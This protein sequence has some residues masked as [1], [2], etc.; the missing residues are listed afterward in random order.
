MTPRPRALIPLLL[1]AALLGAIAAAGALVG[2]PGRAERIPSSFPPRAPSPQTFTSA[3]DLKE[4]ARIAYADLSRQDWA[5]LG[6][7][8]APG[9]GEVGDPCEPGTFAAYAAL[10]IR[11]AALEAEAAL[12]AEHSL[13]AQLVELP[14]IEWELAA[15]EIGPGEASA[16]RR[17][18]AFGRDIAPPVA[19]RDRWRTADGAWWLDPA[20]VAPGLGRERGSLSQ[21]DSLPPPDCAG[22]PPQERSSPGAF[23]NPLEGGAS[24]DATTPDG[25]SLSITLRIGRR[26]SAPFAPD[27]FE[28]V[29]FEARVESRDGAQLGAPLVFQSATFDG[30]LLDR[31]IAAS[32]S[33]CPGAEA[34]GVTCQLTRGA[35]LVAVDD[36]APRIA[37]TPR[38]SLDR[39]EGAVW[40]R[41]PAPQRDGVPVVR[42]VSAPAIAE[43]LA[44]AGVAADVWKTNF[45]RMTIDPAQLRVA[46]T[47]RGAGSALN[48][49]GTGA[50]D[51]IAEADLWM[52]D[53]EPALA[54]EAGG[55]ARAYPL[56]FLL[57][58]P[59]VND[60]L[61]GAPA[62]VTYSPL[63]NTPLA[64]ERRVGVAAPVFQS[65]GAQ[66]F[67]NLIMYDE[68]T[69]SWW[70]QGTGEAV[71]GELA[72]FRLTPLPAQLLSWATFKSAYPSGSALSINAGFAADYDFNPYFDVDFNPPA[73]LRGAELDSRLPTHERVL[74]FRDGGAGGEPLAVPFSDLA[75]QPA[76]HLELDGEPI[77]VFWLRGTASAL[78]HI[79]VARGR[80]VG[81]A[82]AFETTIDG[83]ALTFTAQSGLFVDAQTGS[84]W[85]LTGRAMSGPLEGQ[86]LRPAPHVNSYW[87][88][89]AALNP[90]TGIFRIPLRRAN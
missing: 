31:P 52:G 63:T 64:F 38:G 59:V 43:F 13:Y 86:R 55:E 26:S 45:T 37:W 51:S 53:A 88:A 39:T 18:R 62:L 90:G 70:Q 65:A 82:A 14:R 46:G 9:G 72:G 32:T 75:L 50:Y 76:A 84:A 78:S 56:R 29:P 61:G 5:A 69:E 44:A 21:A 35:A 24:A 10:D 22:E 66:R 3:G 4:F 42:G 7:S 67:N 41:L 54:V 68:A 15:I 30:W 60:E 27:G 49:G 77:V 48:L 1:T 57:W 11:R 83:E 34:T 19:R 47:G 71:A 74:G 36:P 17:A 81:A 20:S 40:W 8:L 12:A 25:K 2:D 33:V 87:F 58:N 16:M 80:D 89:W 85:D 6:R 28:R 23:A 79:N 73:A